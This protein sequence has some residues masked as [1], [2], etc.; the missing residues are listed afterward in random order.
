MFGLGHIDLGPLLY[1]IAMFIGVWVMWIKF[2]RL[3]WLSLIASAAVFWLVF[4]LHGGTMAGGFAAMI[5]AL[6]FDLTLSFMKW[7]KS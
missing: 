1:G 2:I 4:S 5:C 6:L 3:Q 7:R